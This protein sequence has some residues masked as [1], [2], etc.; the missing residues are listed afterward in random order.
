MTFLSDT[1]LTSVLQLGA[2]LYMPATRA[3][4]LA[5][6]AHH[7]IPD[8]RSVILCLEDAVQLADMP[9]AMANIGRL[10]AELNDTPKRL[11]VFIRP[12]N[13]TNLAQLLALADIGNIDGFVLPK[14]DVSNADTYQQLLAGV[15]KLWLM[16]TLETAQIFDGECQRELCARLQSFN[17]TLALR[18]GGNDLLNC[19]HLRRPFTGTI[20]ETPLHSLLGQLCA[21]FLPAG[22]ALTAPVFEH[23]NQLEDLAQELVTDINYGFAGKTI[24]HPKQI[25]TV[26][27]AYKV[28]IREW[29][30]AQAI[31][32]PNAKA[33]FAQAGSMLEPATHRHWATKIIL[34][35]QLFGV[36]TECTPNGNASPNFL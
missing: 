25:T 23:F 31:V 28:S 7:K 36:R 27:N 20:Y 1:P 10:L 8:L 16:P 19:L 3:D 17:N 18:V 6:I 22:F 15:D 5:V 12:R 26:H 30:Q 24:I 9:K 14:F 29:E 21:R 33:V 32:A 4:L 13:V 34:R 11:W 2:S 35:G